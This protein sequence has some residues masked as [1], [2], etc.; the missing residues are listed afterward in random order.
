M[1]CLSCK[2]FYVRRSPTHTPL[3]MFAHYT[4]RTQHTHIHTLLRGHVSAC[5]DGAPSILRATARCERPS[6]CP[7]RGPR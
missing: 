3:R 4:H 6:P 1:P 7:P 5:P 2:T